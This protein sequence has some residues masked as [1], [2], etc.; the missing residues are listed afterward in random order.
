MYTV[1]DPRFTEAGGTNLVG[2]LQLPTRLFF[3]KFVCQNEK[4]G[5]LGGAGFASWIR[6]YRQ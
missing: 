6:W 5:T 3:L 1:A 4:I 2:D